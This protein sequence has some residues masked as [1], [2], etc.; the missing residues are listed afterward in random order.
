[1]SHTRIGWFTG[2]VARELCR[3]RSRFRVLPPE[4]SAAWGGAGSPVTLRFLR[5]ESRVLGL[6]RDPRG[7]SDWR[8]GGPRGLGTKAAF[9]PLADRVGAAEALR[10]RTVAAVPASGPGGCLL[11]PRPPP[12]HPDSE[13]SRHLETDTLP[14]GAGTVVL[15]RG[16]H[17]RYKQAHTAGRPERPRERCLLRGAL[18]GR[19]RRQWAVSSL[20]GAF[21]IG[22][23]PSPATF[24]RPGQ[25][26]T[27]PEALP[28]WSWAAL[29][30]WQQTAI[31]SGVR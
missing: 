3:R 22:H 8:G 7:I 17:N 31:L 13:R 26:L 30:G 4:G 27:E 24:F 12:L 1:M 21:V 14:V 6:F 15:L 5:V 10:K 23:R 28:A 20:S 9:F 29:R 2:E 16:R 18:G 25:T 11:C 19:L